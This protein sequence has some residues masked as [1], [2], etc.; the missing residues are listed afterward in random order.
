[1]KACS[2]SINCIYCIYSRL[3]VA[4][5][6][7]TDTVLEL[8]EISLSILGT[9]RMLAIPY[10]SCLQS[11]KAVSRIRR[12]IEKPRSWLLSRRRCRSVSMRSS[13]M[14]SHSALSL[15][16]DRPSAADMVLTVSLSFGS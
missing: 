15:A 4:V 14:R 9:N 12:H 13:W 3:S 11:P 16:S 2:I 10:H 6:V 1:M 7:T 8:R 5:E